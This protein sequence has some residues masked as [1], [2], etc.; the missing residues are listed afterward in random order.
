MVNFTD[1]L[2]ALKMKY[3]GIKKIISYYSLYFI[4]L[5]KLFLCAV[6]LEF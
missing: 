3:E 5:T 6:E 4:C 2:K 1:V